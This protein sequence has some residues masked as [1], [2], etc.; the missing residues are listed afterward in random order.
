MPSKYYQR[1]FQPG[2]YYHLFN[3][4]AFKSTIFTDEEDYSTFTNILKYY[5]THPFRIAPSLQKRYTL[6]KRNIKERFLDIKPLSFELIAYCLMPNHYHFLIYQKQSPTPENS[7]STFIKQLSLAYYQYFSQK[8]NHSGSLF[9][10]RFKN[11]LVE[12]EEQLLYLSKYIHRNPLPILKKT[13]L[14]SYPY[15]SYQA[16]IGQILTPKWLHPEHILQLPYYQN[17]SNPLK[18]YQ[19]FVK[20]QKDKPSLIKGLTLE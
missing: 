6:R 1:N 13:P 7:P 12:S 19:N 14:K 16:Y 3:R 20:R 10:G 15:S 17:S 2:H 11:V 18:K 8:Y 5:L 9:Q 4:G